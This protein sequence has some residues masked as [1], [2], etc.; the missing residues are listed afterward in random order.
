ME[1]VLERT[2]AQYLVIN[3]LQTLELLTGEFYD[4][5]TGVWYIETLSQTLP[6]AR[7]MPDGEISPLEPV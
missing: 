7:L 3:A 1:T 4:E 2:E 6:I 5:E